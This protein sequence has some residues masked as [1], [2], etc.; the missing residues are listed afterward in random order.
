MIKYLP[1]SDEEMKNMVNSV[2]DN[3]PEIKTDSPRA[4][5]ER[6][7][8]ARI[9]TQFPTCNWSCRRGG[10]QRKKELLRRD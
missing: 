4:L 9:S 7:S 6:D 10:L 3:L 8:R 5:T 2:Y 1:V